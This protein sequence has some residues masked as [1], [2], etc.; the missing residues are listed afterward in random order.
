MENIVEKDVVDNKTFYYASSYKEKKYVQITTH[1]KNIEPYA[2]AKD[3][4][5]YVG[6]AINPSDKKYEIHLMTNLIEIL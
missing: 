6:V 5:D 2:E 1:A 4:Y 3:H